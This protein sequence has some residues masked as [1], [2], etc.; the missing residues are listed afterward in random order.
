MDNDDASNAH[1]KGVGSG[2]GREKG[3]EALYGFGAM[4][5]IAVK[6]G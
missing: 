5:M 2:C 3:F 4:K 1:Q 6:H